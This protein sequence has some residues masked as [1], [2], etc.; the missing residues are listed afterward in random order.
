MSTIVY[1]QN[2]LKIEYGEPGL[3]YFEILDGTDS[4]YGHPVAP[5]V[6]ALQRALDAGLTPVTI[7]GKEADWNVAAFQ[8]ALQHGRTAEFRYA[9]GDGSVIEDRALKPS[10]ITEMGGRTIVVG[11]DV[12]RE[13]PRAFR[14]DR[15]KG[16]VVVT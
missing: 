5:I 15:I 8:A 11:Y 6:S 4:T 9:K 12:D 7:D 14:I 2:D 10:E 13:E 1:E 3:F 16:S